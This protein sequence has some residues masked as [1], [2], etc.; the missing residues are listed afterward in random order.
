MYGYKTIDFLDLRLMCMCWYLS[1]ATWRCPTILIG[2][3]R[4]PRSHVLILLKFMTSSSIFPLLFLEEL[5]AHPWSFSFLWFKPLVSQHLFP[6]FF[7]SLTTLS[8]WV[9]HLLGE[10]L[11]RTRESVN[12]SRWE[13]FK[14]HNKFCRGIELPVRYAEHS[15]AWK[16]DLARFSLLVT[17][18]DTHGLV[19]C[20]F[21]QKKDMW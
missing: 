15:L 14:A 20:N 18:K 4:A 16:W 17:F 7:T 10:G 19:I 5:A 8:W 12:Y 6:F 21:C 9:K 3:A 13:D 1:F 2:R 11:E